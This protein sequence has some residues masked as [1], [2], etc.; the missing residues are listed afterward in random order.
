MQEATFRGRLLRGITH[1]LPDGYQGA[2]TTL[3]QA[4][5]HSRVMFCSLCYDARLSLRMLCAAGV[6][7]T[8][9]PTGEAWRASS[10]FSRFSAWNHDTQPTSADAAPRTLQWLRLASALAAPVDAAE[11]TRRV[12]AA[13]AP[14]GAADGAAAAAADV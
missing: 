9:E 10:G 5:Q 4:R 1:E 7:L 6:V 12:D 14:A 3:S 11:V 8:R 2:P 13:A